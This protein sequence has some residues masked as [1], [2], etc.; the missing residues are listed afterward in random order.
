M[1]DSKD[2]T[3]LELPG[4]ELA[5]LASTSLSKKKA[6][7]NPTVHAA[8]SKISRKTRAIRQSQLEL[9]A[10]LGQT[11]QSGLPAWIQ[12]EGLD[13]SGLPIWGLSPSE[14]NANIINT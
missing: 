12:D 6:L 11:D 4:F 13:Q 8:D 7:T 5:D 1:R 2:H 9:L 10:P 14:N 3:T